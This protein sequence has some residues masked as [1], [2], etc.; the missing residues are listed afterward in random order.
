MVSHVV[1][2]GKRG[3]TRGSGARSGAVRRRGPVRGKEKKARSGKAGGVLAAGGAFSPDRLLE[4]GGGS[5]GRV[6][7]AAGGT[8]GATGERGAPPPLPVPIASFTI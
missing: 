7:V 5:N 4:G 8:G 1:K 2:T 6:A 3:K